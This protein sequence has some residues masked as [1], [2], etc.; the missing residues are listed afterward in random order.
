MARGRSAGD[1]IC[2][3]AAADRRASAGTGDARTRAVANAGYPGPRGGHWAERLCARYSDS[4]SDA[5]T[6]P[7]SNANTDSDAETN[8][9]TKANSHAEGESD[10]EALA[11][12]NTE[13]EAFANAA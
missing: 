11:N 9:N 13:A 10:A 4:N 5:D 12:G 1:H 6:N 3:N 7:D 8:S 2:R